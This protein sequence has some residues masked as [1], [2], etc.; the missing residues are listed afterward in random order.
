LS[1]RNYAAKLLTNQTAVV[2]ANPANKADTVFLE[3][4]QS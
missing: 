2:R 3:F 1:A 4:D